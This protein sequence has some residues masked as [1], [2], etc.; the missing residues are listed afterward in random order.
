M[1]GLVKAKDNATL[2]RGE[3]R[4]GYTRTGAREITGLTLLQY[5]QLLRYLHL[6][7]AD[8]RPDVNTSQHDKC[9]YVR[10]LIKALQQA[11]ARWF[12]PGKDNG[13]DEAGIPS[14]MRFLRR[15]NSDKPHKYF[16]EM[17]MG[18]DSLTKFCWYFFVSESAMKTVRNTTRDASRTSKSARSKFCRVSHYQPEFN[19]DERLLQDELGP[20][21]AQVCHFARKLREIS[22]DDVDLE[23]GGI[24]YRIFVDRRWDSVP[25]SLYLVLFMPGEY[26]KYRTLQQSCERTGTMSLVDPSTPVLANMSRNPRSVSHLSLITYRTHTHSHTFGHRCAR[27]VVNIVLQRRLSVSAMRR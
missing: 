13:V 26:T 10:P 21:A 7:R 12:V 25:S 14:R 2:F 15:Y 9:F 8:K 3:S 4:A 22:N 1:R 11:F 27:T 5:E 23:D 17:I 19:G 6:C 16:M 18:C 20:T 24:I